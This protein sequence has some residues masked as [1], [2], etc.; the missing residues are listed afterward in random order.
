M[1]KNPDRPAATAEQV[2]Y[3]RHIYHVDPDPALRNPDNLAHVF[4]SPLVR[5]FTHP[6]A[7]WVWLLR[8]Y[9][10]GILEYH[11]VR[12]RHIDAILEENLADGLEQLVLLGAG[13]DS[14][15]YRFREQ[16]RDVKIFELDLRSTQERKKKCLKKHFG[17]LPGHVT[18]VPVNFDRES[19][20]DRL[21]E[22]GYDATRRTLFNWEG[23][24]MFLEPQSVDATVRL[25]AENAGAGSAIVFDYLLQS[26]LEGDVSYPGTQQMFKH[27][28]RRGEP[29]VFGL[30]GAEGTASYL[31]ERGLT[32][33][34]DLGTEELTERYIPSPER[35]AFGPF[36][37][38]HARKA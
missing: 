35:P 6:R 31:A 34:T 30:P 17:T 33:V 1:P 15:P 38:V 5:V 21:T 7:F 32:T 14:R 18:F 11:L 26:V 12:T 24:C 27:C 4:L 9:G 29:L 2:A 19:I 10:N 16:L 13:Y 25:V 3:M 8:K 36:R 22:S 20:L 28:E 23:V 37:I